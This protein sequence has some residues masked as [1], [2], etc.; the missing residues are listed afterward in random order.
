MSEEGRLSGPGSLSGAGSLSAP[1]S[2]AVATPADSTAAPAY[3]I[4]PDEPLAQLAARYG[5]KPSAARPSILLYM[6]QLWQRRHF[7]VGFAP[8]RNLAMYTEARLGQ[9]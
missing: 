2:L 4:L 1:G 7:I 5:L 8:A 9:L 3:A 6:R